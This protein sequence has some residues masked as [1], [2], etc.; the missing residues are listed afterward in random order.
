MI[1]DE[2]SEPAEAVLASTDRAID[3]D[4]NLRLLANRRRRFCLYY[5]LQ[6]DGSAEITELA[7]LIE[8][9][10]TPPDEE[11]TDTA[12]EEGLVALVHYHLPK[13][14]DAGLI[15]VDNG[16]VRLV[17]SPEVPIREW[18]TTL[19]TIELPPSQC[20]ALRAR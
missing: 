19:A 18:L 14:L 8:A 3:I 6:L 17:E 20:A 5:L 15:D 7:E 4:D 13:L 2:P 9:S 12:F 1:A 11:I 10:I 16:T